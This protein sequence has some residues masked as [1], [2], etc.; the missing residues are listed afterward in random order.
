MLTVVSFAQLVACTWS[1]GVYVVESPSAIVRF[2]MLYPA[3]QMLC[4]A[5]VGTD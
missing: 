3:A 1:G 2:R 4:G 5:C